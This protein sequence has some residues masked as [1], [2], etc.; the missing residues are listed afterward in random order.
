MDA[1]R[2]TVYILTNTR[3]TVLYIG[4]TNDLER[5]M[6]EHRA[7]QFEGFSKRYRLR[8]LLYVEHFSEVRDAL[9][10]EKQLKNW[11]RAW[12]LDLIRK[13]NPDMR[14]LWMSPSIVR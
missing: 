7:G 8:K 2:Y 4:M 11:R 12:K 5:R 14:D 13:H 9:Y 6:L 3:N 10:R 1:R